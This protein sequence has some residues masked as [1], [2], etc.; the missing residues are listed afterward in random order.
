MAN[1][2]N[3]FKKPEKRALSKDTPGIQAILSAP[4]YSGVTINE[5]TVFNLSVFWCGVRVLAEAV[6]SLPLILY[7]RQDEGRT[8]ASDHP[9][10]RLLHDEPNAEQTDIMFRE[11]MMTAML[12]YGNAYAE[13][14]R[15]GSGQV[16]ALWQIP[17]NWVKVD[18]TKDSLARLIYEVR[19]PAGQLRQL[20][21]SDVLHIAGLGNGLVGFSILDK[22]RQTLGLTKAFEDSEAYIFGNGARPSGWLK[23]PGVLDEQGRQNLARSFK[24]Q[25]QGLENTGAVPLLEE[26]AEFVPAAIN[27]HDAEMLGLRKFQTEEWARIF[28]LPP[29]KLKDLGRATWS[30]IESENLSFVTDSLRPYLVKWE[31][32]INRKLLSPA[33]KTSYY[34]EHLLDALLRGDTT[35][36]TQSL[37]TQFINGAINL[38][39][40]RQLENRNP[41]EGGEDHYVPANLVKL[42]TA[43]PAAPGAAP[44]TPGEPAEPVTPD[45]SDA[46]ASNDLRA[47]VGGSAQILAMQQAYSS[48]QITRDMAIA[49]ATIVFGF[50]QQEAEALFPLELPEKEIQPQGL[51]TGNGQDGNQNDSEDEAGQE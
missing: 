6:S 2:F 13:I 47:T 42:D 7:R 51:D 39:E 28:N 8:R 4:T 23:Y 19:Q 43:Q 16:I 41:V 21:A 40:W 30:N 24:A 48:G 29:H 36:R 33:E 34:T 3:W 11:S 15:N 32:E 49:N 44:A 14:Q 31:K 35:T 45:Q 46:A 10:Y 27:P 12:V 5:T 37:Q 38:N 18:R 26:G 1:W 25:W 20:E 22:F 9:L 50:S 17:S